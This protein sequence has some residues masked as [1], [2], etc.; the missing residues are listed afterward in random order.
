MVLLVCARKGIRMTRSWRLAS[1]LQRKPGFTLVEL[2]V[3]IAIIGI[4]VSL[5]LPAVQSAREAARRLACGNNLRQFALALHHYQ[6]TFEAF[7]TGGW[8]CD[9]TN[10]W[11][12]FHLHIS[13]LPYMEQGTLY[14]K[15]N[16]SL[17]PR[18]FRFPATDELAGLPMGALRI[19]T[20]TCPSDSNNMIGA[21][22]TARWAPNY[23]PSRGPT[24]LPDNSACSCPAWQPLQQTYGS[25]GHKVWNFHSNNNPAGLFTRSTVDPTTGIYTPY[26]G[27]IS[28]VKDGMSNLIVIGETR[29][30]CSDH[31]RMGWHNPEG[32]GLNSTIIPIN[33]DSCA[34]TL[35]DAPGGNG[36]RARCNWNMEMGF[37]SLH[38]TGAHFVY[39]DGST[40]FL[41]KSMDHWAYNYLGDKCDGTTV[42]LP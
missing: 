18:T 35:A 24:P 9:N 26:Y 12:R 37:R 8:C 33:Y 38:P 39:G 5:L 32:L 16:A 28:D 13:L 7:P 27:K 4:L 34:P 3:V 41:H 1:S 42:Q 22:S 11:Y 15:V 21:G 14:A 30:E 19:P 36:C 29:A 25:A 40:H 31:L 2:L 20:Y 10:R 17:D 6:V 23:A